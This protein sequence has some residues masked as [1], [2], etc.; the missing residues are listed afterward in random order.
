MFPLRSNGALT[1]CV[2]RSWMYHLSPFTYLIDALVSNAL[3]G[4]TIRCKQDQFQVLNPPANEQCVNWLQPYTQTYGGY[5]E[6]LQN[7]DCGYCTYATGDQFLSTVGMSYSHRWRNVGF[8][9]AVSLIP[10]LF[11]ARERPPVNRIELRETDLDSFLTR[12]T[13]SSTSS[14][15]LSAPGFTARSSG[16]VSSRGRTRQRRTKRSKTRRVPKN[17]KLAFSCAR[18]FPFPLQ[19]AYSIDSLL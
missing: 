14:L 2:S 16:E 11:G 15:S 19:L 9:C 13:S 17:R 12:S 10:T 18:H 6:V 1:Y 7:G 3:G 5:A 8:L 4:V